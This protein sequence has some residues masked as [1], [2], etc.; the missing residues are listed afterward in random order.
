MSD[1]LQVASTSDTLESVQ[2][3]ANGTA[4]GVPVSE[5]SL[6]QFT[7]SEDGRTVTYENSNSERQALLERLRQAEEEIKFPIETEE[8]SVAESES[9][10]D[11]T[12]LKAAKDAIAATIDQQAV[13]DAI[14]DARRSMGLGDDGMNTV[15]PAGGPTR[16]FYTRM[17]ELRA[18]DPQGIQ[19]LQENAKDIYVAPEVG[20]LLVNHS[21]GIDLMIALAKNPAVAS[22]LYAMPIA[23]QV[24]EVQEALA[25]TR[26]QAARAAATPRKTVSKAPPPIKPV[27]G[28]TTKSSLPPD[29]L[30]YDEW[31]VWRD[32]E[33]KQR[34]RK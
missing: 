14:A 33:A 25:V 19:V 6:S 4:E 24:Q 21:H 30:P 3:A 8:S 29:D 17:G 11:E 7:E 2:A 10:A 31:R 32:R 1:E 23:Q 13:A 16:E 15:Q 9:A 28:S 26:W 22:Q 20:Q 12:D 5:S 27:G 18:V 34:Y